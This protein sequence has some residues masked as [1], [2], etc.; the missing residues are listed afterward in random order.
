MRM[1]LLNTS[2][3][4]DGDIHIQGGI[5]GVGGVIVGGG[6]VEVIGGRAITVRNEAVDSDEVAK[7]IDELTLGGISDDAT[8]DPD[9]DGF[10]STLQ[11]NI[12]SK[13][14]MTLSTYV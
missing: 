9:G 13:K 10:T 6:T 12:Y 7:E 8:G 11:L 3:T 5:A 2:F 14:D 4:A 1:L